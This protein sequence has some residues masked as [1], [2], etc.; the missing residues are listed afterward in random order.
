MPWEEIT[1]PEKR[2][3]FVLLAGKEGCNMSVLCQRF[4]ISRKTGYKWLKRHA[5]ASTAETLRDRSRRPLH[6]PHRSTVALEEAVVSIRRAHPVWGGRKIAHVQARDRQLELVPSTVT[7]ILR[8]HGLIEPTVSEAAKP[9]QRFEHEYPNSLLQMDFKG[10]FAVGNAHSHPLTI[11]DDH[12]RYTWRWWSARTS[13]APRY[14]RCLG[15]SSPNMACCGVSISIM[16]RLGA[17]VVRSAS[18][19]WRVKEYPRRGLP[20]MG[21]VPP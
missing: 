17:H 3:E 7:R 16:A 18:T 1:V 13:N 8:C 4:G 10:H 19:A 12:S 6:L 5:C 20:G 15:A 2:A 11:L 9:W 14:R 21:P